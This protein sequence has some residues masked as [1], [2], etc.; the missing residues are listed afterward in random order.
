[1]VAESAL[2]IVKSHDSL[3]GKQGGILTPATAFG[4]V[5]ID[6]LTHDGG[7]VF[8]VSDIPSHS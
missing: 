1:M 4:Q 2:S 6:R 5:L 7:M 3:P 8:E